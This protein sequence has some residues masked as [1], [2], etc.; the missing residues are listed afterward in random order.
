MSPKGRKSPSRNPE[1]GAPLSR[2]GHPSP[3]L[4][5]KGME[6]SQ[7]DPRH[8]SHPCRRK[9]PTARLSQ[10]CSPDPGKTD[11]SKAGERLSC[12]SEGW[13][14]GKALGQAE[15][16]GLAFQGEGNTSPIIS[17][18]VWA[19]SPSQE[20]EAQ[21][22]GGRTAASGSPGVRTTDPLATGAPADSRRLG[23]EEDAA[24][25][26][27]GR[28]MMPMDQT[29][30]TCLGHRSL[31]S[32]QLC[33]GGCVFSHRWSRGLAAA[34]PPNP[35]SSLHSGWPR[36]LRQDPNYSESQRASQS[37]QVDERLNFSLQKGELIGEA[38][39]VPRGQPTTPVLIRSCQ[40]PATGQASCQ[41]LV[42]TE[43]ALHPEQLA[44]DAKPPRGGISRASA[45]R[46]PSPGTT[47]TH[48]LQG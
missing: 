23:T 43:R 45:S 1:H 31:P 27:K 29:E 18:T 47:R 37:P 42:C 20:R 11:P 33:S 30:E 7:G 2:K 21:L 44:G 48:S 32:V 41:G 28:P 6:G 9:M 38:G 12:L 40:L 25:A 15:R 26:L 46:T 16:E 39:V 8:A 4:C 35:A 13:C 19:P 10:T 34:H 22:P 5:L 17:R 14:R 36:T 3:N 24:T